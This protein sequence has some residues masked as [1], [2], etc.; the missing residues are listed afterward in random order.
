MGHPTFLSKAK[1][2]ESDSDD[3]EPNKNGSPVF[4]LCANLT[5][6]SREHSFIT[7]EHKKIQ[8]D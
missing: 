5:K 6:R 1:P 3:S 4:L 2:I 7:R 8:Y